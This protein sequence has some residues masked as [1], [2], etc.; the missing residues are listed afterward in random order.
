MGFKVTVVLACFARHRLTEALNYVKKNADYTTKPTDDGR[1]RQLLITGVNFTQKFA[2]AV[3][4]ELNLRSECYCLSVSST[5]FF[6]DYSIIWVKMFKKTAFIKMV[7]GDV[8][9]THLK[10]QKFTVLLDS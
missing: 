10:Q 9:N 5:V 8:A 7:I 3:E 2:T 1:Q 6:M 4:T